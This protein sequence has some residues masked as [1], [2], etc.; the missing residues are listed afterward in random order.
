[1]I[2]LLTCSR[3]SSV[4]IL[5]FIPL[6]FVVLL[7]ETFKSLGSSKN[8]IIQNDCVF[9]IGVYF[10]SKRNVFYYANALK[11]MKQSPQQLFI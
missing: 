1:M 3:F 9:C 6:Y 7:S 4:F 2:L 5:S 11:E 8:Q 10:R